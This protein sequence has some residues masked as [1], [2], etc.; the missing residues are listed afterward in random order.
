[1]SHQILELEQIEMQLATKTSSPLICPI[2]GPDSALDN[3]P[4]QT[5]AVYLFGGVRLLYSEMKKLF[6]KL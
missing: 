6:N 3:P 4:F 5:R 1:M 2:N